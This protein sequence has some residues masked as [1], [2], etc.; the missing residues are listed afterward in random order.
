M[1]NPGSAGERPGVA[2]DQFRVATRVAFWSIIETNSMPP[3]DAMRLA[4]MA[5]GSL[6]REVASAHCKASGCACGWQPCGAGD[7]ETLMMALRAGAQ[8]VPHAPTDLF[9]AKAAGSA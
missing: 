9:A 5:L 4:A 6:Y 2:L 1:L 7:V 3:L 8:G